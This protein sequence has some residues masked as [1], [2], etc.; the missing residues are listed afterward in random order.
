VIFLRVED[1]ERAALHVENYNEAVFQ[2]ANSALKEGSQ[3]VVYGM[4]GK[5]PLMET[6]IAAAAAGSAQRKSGRPPARGLHGSEN[7]ES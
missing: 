4:G 3:I 5:E 7:R 2:A 1:P 6:T